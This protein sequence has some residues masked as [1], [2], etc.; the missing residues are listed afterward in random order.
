MAGAVRKEHRRPTLHRTPGSSCIPRNSHRSALRAVAQ[1]GAAGTLNIATGADPDLAVPTP[2]FQ[3]ANLDVADLLCL[4]LAE[5][6]PTRAAPGD[7]TASD[8]RGGDRRNVARGVPVPRA[9][10]GS[11]W[12]WGWPVAAIGSRA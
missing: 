7:R 5:P 8:R 9:C 2:G 6:E 11:S 3:G 10:S 1:D 4:R 12:T